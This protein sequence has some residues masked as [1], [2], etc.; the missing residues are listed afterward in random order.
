MHLTRPKDGFILGGMLPMKFVGTFQS[1]ILLNDF[2]INPT[3]I[4]ES[5]NKFQ[6]A[7]VGLLMMKKPLIFGFWYRNEG[8]YYQAKH[9]D[10]FIM[11]FGVNLNLKDE[12]TLKIMYSADFTISQLRS[13]SFAS[14][15]IS[16]VYNLD[17]RY[18]FQAYRAKRSR[19]KFFKCPTEFKG[20]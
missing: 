5:Q 7:T 9:F 13:S 10:S 11:A 16:L 17:N 8:I 20:L 1:A 6:T 19:A 12:S 15:E 18:M 3:V 4:Y 14:H 2:V